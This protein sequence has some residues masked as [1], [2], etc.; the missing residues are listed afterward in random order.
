MLGK[1][2]LATV[3]PDT[4]YV[5]IAVSGA[6][7]GKTIDFREFASRGMQ[8]VGMTQQYKDGVLYF[9]DDLA[10]NIAHGDKS[11]LNMLN[12]ADEYVQHNGLDL[13]R[14]EEAKTITADPECVTK[15]IRQVDLQGAGITSVI[16]A[17][18]YRSDFGWLKAD[19]FDSE[20]KPVHQRGVTFEQGIYFVGLPWL[21]RRGSSFIW[22][23][24]HDAKYIADHITTQQRYRRYQPG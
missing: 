16:W 3:D 22:G 18:G 24:W 1:W 7:V 13:P 6:Y 2:D 15:P 19:V 5:T 21:S 20:G 11:L 4:A 9:A 12:E 8:L 17:T 23:V 14:E 10:R